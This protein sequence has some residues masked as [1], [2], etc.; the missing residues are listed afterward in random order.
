[1]RKQLGSL[2]HWE[3]GFANA[4]DPETRRLGEPDGRLV[5]RSASRR[6]LQHVPPLRLAVSALPAVHDLSGKKK[7]ERERP[8]YDISLLSTLARTFILKAV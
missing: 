4:G 8:L 6:F 7:G 5:L 1:M 2:G 3:H